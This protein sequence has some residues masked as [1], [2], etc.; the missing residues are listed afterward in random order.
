[1]N[2]LILLITAILILYAS[3]IKAENIAEDLA[4]KIIRNYPSEKFI[5]GVG[6]VEVSGDA[7]KDRR[8]AEILA[9]L[10]IAKLIKTTVKVSS[11]IVMCEG[12]AKTLYDN[13]TECR[14]HFEEVIEESVDEVLEGSK[15]IETGDIKKSGKNIFYA[16]A[17][18]PKKGAVEKVDTFSKQAVGDIKKAE[19]Y[20]SEKDAIERIKQD[21]DSLLEQLR[22]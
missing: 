8:G 17:V 9:R 4:G 1:M 22:R 10:E 19:A 18:L 3:S 2:K 14:N 13:Q 12:K 7:Y 16:I 20:N 5:I 11:I 15:I 6:I 21:A